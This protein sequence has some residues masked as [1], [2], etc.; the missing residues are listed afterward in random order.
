V[1]ADKAYFHHTPTGPAGRAYVVKGDTLQI[2]KG[3]DDKFPK[4]DFSPWFESG[5]DTIGFVDAKD[6][7]P[8]P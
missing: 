8:L 1:L 4:T 2:V 3:G 7:V 5:P 6:L